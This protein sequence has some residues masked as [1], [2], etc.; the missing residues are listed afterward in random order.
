MK[1]L[2]VS[3]SPRAEGNT[4]AMLKETLAA[5]AAEGAEVELYSVAGKD[6]QPCDGCWACIEAGRCHRADDAE[7]LFEKMLAADGIVFGVPVYFHGMTAQ[8]KAIV[9]RTI[10]LGSPERNLT[11]KVCG[12]VASAGSL[13]LIQVLKD[14][15]YYAH[16][17]DMLPANHVAAY[18]GPRSS[19]EQMPK[20]RQ[21]LR[22]LGRQMVSLIKVE[23][24]FPPEFVGRFTTF[25]THTM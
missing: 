10:S 4:V 20:C 6:I 23:F 15:T 14:F 3:C 25:G 21:E 13:G 7:E 1:I 18:L 19:L 5:A 16:V 22:D 11:N 9:D 12:V 2:A 17:K 24:R 8:A